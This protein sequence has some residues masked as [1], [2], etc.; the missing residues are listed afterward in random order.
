MFKKRLYPFWLFLKILF[1]VNIR[2]IF[3]TWRIT[4]LPQPAVTI[5]G[6]SKLVLENEHAQRACTLATKLAER[7]FS[8]ITGGGPG[9]MEAANLGAY[10]QIQRCEHGE[11]CEFITGSMGIGLTYLNREK[12]NPY[13]QQFIIMDHFFE[14][15]W[16]LVRN[17][18]GF[19]VF[20]G[21]YGTFDELF[22]ILTLMQCGR[23]PII[24]V[25]LMGVEYWAP[26]VAFFRQRV[27]R[28]GLID[29]KDLEL[30]VLTDD[31]DEAL[32]VIGSGYEQYLK[33]K[34]FRR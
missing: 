27:L 15:K 8:I 4:A 30:F 20:P 2:L 23:M 25:V 34:K 1:K 7:G 6:G 13:L 24:P 18:I 21:G 31:V 28:D 11:K 17:A 10:Q 29:E 33:R 22:E 26:V 5:F 14:R 19:V 3:G 9:I 16:L 12:P 32:S